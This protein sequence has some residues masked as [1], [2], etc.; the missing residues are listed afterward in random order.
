[1][2]N[3]AQKSTTASV[4]TEKS[5]LHPRNRH[6]ERY[7]FEGLVQVNPDLARFVKLN[8]Y[9]DKSIDFSNPKAVKAL[10]QAL[11]MQ[12]YA[13]RDWDIPA[14]YL[15]PP[16]PGRA[17]YLHYIADL[18]AASNGG[19][20]PYGDS[21]RVLDIG[22]GANAVYPLIGHRE[23]GWRFVGCDIDPAAISNAQRIVDAN[24][25]L[26]E[27]IELRMQ[28]ASSSIFNGVIHPGEVFDLTMCNPPFHASLDDADQGS[29]RKWQN[30]GKGRGREQ[31]PVLNFGGQGAELYCEGG[32]AAFVTR[33]INESAQ[34]ATQ[35]YWVTTLISKEA[36]LP[37]VYR[38]LR[39][40][41]AADVKTMDMAQGQKKSRVVAWTFLNA[42]QQQAWR[43]RHWQSADRNR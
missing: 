9:H 17:D 29:R 7:D 34:Y 3:S 23:Y 4:A 13:I 1:M 6:R 28:G 11:L 31:A 20:I 43:D 19:G 10:N 27:K 22:V 33:M 15:C 24:E 42:G 30:L 26:S 38:A 32:E 37:G 12:H 41:R 16:I 18:L 39:K 36:N 14:Q 35:C 40:V 25:G 8:E 21:I 2:T 5:G